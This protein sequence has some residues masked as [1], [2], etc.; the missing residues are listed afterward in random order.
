M[1]RRILKISAIFSMWASG[2]LAQAVEPTPTPTPTKARQ[3]WELEWAYLSKYREAD[4]K[5]G[6][7]GTAEKRVVF[8]GDSITEHWATIDAAFFSR[9]GF[10]GRGIGGQTTSQLLVRFRQDVIALKPA[11]VVILGGTNDIAQNG[12]ITT[13]G[14][15][16]DNLHSMVDLARLNG[17]RVV[18]A[19]VLPAVDYPW[20]KG[21]KPAD[22]ITAL[23]Q[24]IS[25]FCQA[26][27]L[28]Y[29]DYY[30]AVVDEKQAM[31][32]GLASDGVHPTAAGYAVME[33]LA[34][35]AVSAALSAE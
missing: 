10:V 18:L 35:N 12:G 19:S 15:I 34:E 28:V 11:V 25:G 21:L 9:T 4:E 20:R 16:E 6:P 5:L 7:P 2:A 27:H 30:S 31:R 32:D 8:L 33:P 26:N 13:L 29:L 3:P 22:K 23:N 1:N 14:A 24:W 17:I